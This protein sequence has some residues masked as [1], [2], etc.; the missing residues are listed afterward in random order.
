M[1]R[2]YLHKYQAEERFSIVSHC[3]LYSFIIYF[4]P[5]A[6]RAECRW[7]QPTK[8]SSNAVQ[9][10]FQLRDDTSAAADPATEYIVTP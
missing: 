3:I 9:N 2:D 10:L 7:H 1:S 6:L 8:Q 4:F 5:L